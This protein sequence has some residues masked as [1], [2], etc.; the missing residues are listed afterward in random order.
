M[1]D[2]RDPWSG[3]Y[4]PRKPSGDDD[5]GPKQKQPRRSKPTKKR[6]SHTEA[7]RE[8]T[9]ASGAAATAPPPQTPTQ[10]GGTPTVTA[11]PPPPELLSGPNLPFVI[12]IAIALG[13][14][15][16]YLA[17]FDGV[18]KV[19]GRSG[20]GA[21]APTTTAAV[22]GTTLTPSGTSE[23]ASG[24][25]AATTVATT[26]P[27]SPL[28][29]LGSQV[30][31]ESLAYPVFAT[32]PPGDDRIYVIERQGRILIFDEAV[33]AP[34]ATPFLDIT[35]QVDDA[36]GIE[37][38]LLG[39]AFHPDYQTNGRYFV[40]YTDNVQDPRL[41]E[42]TASG[43]TTDPGTERLMITYLKDT[44]RHNGGMLQFG[45]DGY[46]YVA[47]GDG[48]TGGEFAQALDDIRGSILRIDVDSGDPYGIPA[49]NPFTGGDAP[50]IWAYGL[51]NPWRFAIDSVEEMIYIADVGQGRYEE[52]N[53]A[54]L[55]DPGAN[56][57]WPRTEGE[58][59]WIP[60][61]GCD[62]S[63][64]TFPEVLYDH[65]GGCSITGGFVYRGTQIPELVGHYFYADWCG[66]WI[67]SFRLEGDEETDTRD[68]SDDLGR[69]G[70]VTSFGTDASGELLVLTSE[71]AMIRLLPVR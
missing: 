31:T 25:D 47:V 42:F 69:V 19:F 5:A 30:L 28:A 64:Q 14:L 63:G 58:A 49:D 18:D 65:N 70:S 1:P 50:E 9:A 57:G 6:R 71:G 26:Q 29:G 54:S 23:G 11:K 48:A 66:G 17:A 51:R 40:Y 61:T 2:E 55:G 32:T 12:A 41:V 13:A 59:C 45:P 8:Q 22:T 56:F 34:L 52:V 68:W 10:P 35:D 60:E 27:S 33:G 38:G 7:R 46:L 15:T 62:T 39:L 44:V 3:E 16:A 43:D 67:R 4:T 21:A 53:I 36:T 20:D 37:L 24:T